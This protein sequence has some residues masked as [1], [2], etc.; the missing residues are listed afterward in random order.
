MTQEPYYYLPQFLSQAEADALYEHSQALS[1][2]QNDIR[3]F[4]KLSLSLVWKLSMA[5]RDAAISI[6]RRY[7]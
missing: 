5:M 7:F 1:W 3:M 4:G 6:R 2:Q